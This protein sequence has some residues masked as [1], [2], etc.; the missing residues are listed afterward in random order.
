MSILSITKVIVACLLFLW[1]AFAVGFWLL[2]SNSVAQ[3]S[4]IRNRIAAETANE[5]GL[6]TKLLLYYCI[7]TRCI[8]F[9]R[10]LLQRF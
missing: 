4:T 6:Y 8:R 3:Q 7:P 2:D 1:I 9:G 10:Y 5:N